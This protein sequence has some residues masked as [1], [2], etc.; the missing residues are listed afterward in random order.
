MHV[1]SSCCCAAEINPTGI[2]DDACGFDPWPQSLGQ[3]SGVAMSCGVS[4]RCGLDSELLWLWLYCKIAAVAPIR[5]LGMEIP[6]DA[7]G[8]LKGKKKKKKKKKK[9]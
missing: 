1:W 6:H 3:G 4:H 8:V 2:H 9:K 5:P 7:C